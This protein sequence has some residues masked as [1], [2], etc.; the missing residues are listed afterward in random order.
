MPTSDTKTI[1]AW[2]PKEL[3][4][5]IYKFS[6]GPVNSLVPKPKWSR[7]LVEFRGN[8]FKID[9]VIYGNYGN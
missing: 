8:C 7:N 6:T 3:L 9:N 1:I 2:K 5:E 4:D